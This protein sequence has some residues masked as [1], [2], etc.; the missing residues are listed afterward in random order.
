MEIWES[1]GL[2]VTSSD[3]G[4]MK[5]TL[6]LIPDRQMREKDRRR[7][8]RPTWDGWN[9]AQERAQHTTLL[10]SPGLDSMA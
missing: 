4:K 9:E 2:P 1:Q 10:G 8:E 5:P 3:M 6:P 7:M